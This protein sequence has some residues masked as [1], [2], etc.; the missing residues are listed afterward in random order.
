MSAILNGLC[1]LNTK[2]GTFRH[3]GCKNFRHGILRQK[4]KKA[5][6]AAFLSVLT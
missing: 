4:A 3:R 1:A 2:A 6:A 5:A